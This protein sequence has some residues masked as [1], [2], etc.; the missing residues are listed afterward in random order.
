MPTTYAINNGRTVMDATLYTGNGTGQSVVNTD[1]G[2]TGF[3]PDLVWMKTRNLSNFNLLVDSNRGVGKWLSSNVTLAE[4][5]ADTNVLTAFNTNGF[6]VGA[7]PQNSNAG[8]NPSGL[9]QVAWQWQAGQGTNTSNTAGTI[10]STVSANTTAGFSIVTYTGNGVASTIGHGLGVAP[11]MIIIKGR[12]T[13][14]SWPTYHSSLGNN[15]V[16]YLNETAASQG[17]SGFNNTTPTSTVFSIGPPN[18]DINQ[19]SATYVA[20]CWAPVAG[21]SQFG[22]YTGNGS[23]DGP[24]IYTGFRPRFY[25]FKRTDSAGNWG[26]FDTVRGPYN[27]NTPYLYPN[28][29]TAES[30]ANN[31]LD[32]LSNGFKI[33]SA[34]SA[35]WNANGGT[36]IYMAF[37]E[38]PF[39]YANAR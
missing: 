38:N 3:K 32:F 4:N 6:T 16:L 26:T 27:V 13:T 30:T 19:S 10:T 24:F 15:N 7:D 23:S 36:Y 37:A 2:T 21:F 17:F 14:F 9:L 33:R 5:T 25:M 28:A 12:S 18:N 8:W 31:I 22:S 1:Q 34:A 20:Y 29:S 11:S 35:D 39:K